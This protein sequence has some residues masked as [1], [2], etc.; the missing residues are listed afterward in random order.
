MR[1]SFLGASAHQQG[2]SAREDLAR[3]LLAL[4]STFWRALD[5]ANGEGLPCLHTHGRGTGSLRLPPTRRWMQ[6]RGWNAIARPKQ[7]VCRYQAESS[8]SARRMRRTVEVVHGQRAGGRREPM[9]KAAESAMIMRSPPHSYL[10]DELPASEC[11][12]KVNSGVTSTTR[13]PRLVS[14]IRHA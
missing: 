3:L 1:H 9:P 13:S 12:A 4:F 5:F 11:A 10:N 14:C 8:A 6:G 7:M 2:R